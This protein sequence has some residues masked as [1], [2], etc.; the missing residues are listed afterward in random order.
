MLRNLSRRTHPNLK[1]CEGYVLSFSEDKQNTTIYVLNKTLKTF[2]LSKL[3]VLYIKM[4]HIKLSLSPRLSERKNARRK[5]DSLFKNHIHLTYRGCPSEKN[6]RRKYDYSPK[7]N[8]LFQQ[9]QKLFISAAAF[10]C[11]IWNIQSR[12]I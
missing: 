4:F 2:D 3:K 11:F 10:K 1:L 7:K 5:Y 9:Q 6:A 12:S 8:S